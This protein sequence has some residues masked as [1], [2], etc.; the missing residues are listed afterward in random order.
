LP[1]E[2]VDHYVRL[3]GTRAYKLLG[4]ACVRADLGR[5][6]GGA[7]YQR[8]AEFLQREEWAST[9]EDILERRTK[10]GLHLTPEQKQAFTDWM[11]TMAKS[12]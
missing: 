11:F 7:L 9:P 8:E 6:F 3:Y 2:V 1:R 12:A 10:H 4:G 5:H